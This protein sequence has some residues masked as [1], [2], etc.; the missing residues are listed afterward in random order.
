MATLP[1][2]PVFLAIV[3]L[4]VVAEWLWRTRIARRGYDVGAAAASLGVAVGSILLKPLTAGV[5]AAVFSAASGLAPIH[6]PID[7]WRVWAAGFVLVE[8]VYYWFHRWSHTVRW[9][10]A[11]HSVHHSPSEFTLP[12]AIR[13]GWTGVLSGGWLLFVPLVIAGFPPV[14]IAALLAFNLSYQFFLHTEA[15]GRLGPL[16]QVL[17][18]PSHHRVH[19]ASN[20]EYLDRNFGGVLIVFDRLFGTFSEEHP[21]TSPRYGLVHPNPSKNPITISLAEWRRLLAD[22]GKARTVSDLANTLVGRP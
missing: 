15:V 8:F 12:A 7:D 1:R 22:A 9:L 11:S 16:E 21:E 4:L 6:L 13:L 19:H 2:S 14:V 20:L 18:T 5:T 10:W 3:V 17:N